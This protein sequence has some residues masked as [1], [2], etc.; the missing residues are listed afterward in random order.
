MRPEAEQENKE[1]DEWGMMNEEFFLNLL[2]SEG[3]KSSESSFSSDWEEE[4]LQD[5]QDF[6]RPRAEQETLS[7]VNRKQSIFL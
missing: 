6:A 7:L 5:L 4:K 3:E 1:N 2:K